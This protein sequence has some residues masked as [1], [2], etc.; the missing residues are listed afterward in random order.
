MH[1]INYTNTIPDESLLYTL[2]VSR[3]KWELEAQLL[4]CTFAVSD[5]G[6]DTWSESVSKN[7]NYINHPLAPRLHG[8]VDNW[9]TIRSDSSV[10]CQAQ[11]FHIAYLLTWITGTMPISLDT[12]KGPIS[13]PLIDLL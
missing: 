3:T 4:A 8:V 13:L 12:W 10:L 1:I 2:I 5:P 9:L 7:L 11:P 6:I